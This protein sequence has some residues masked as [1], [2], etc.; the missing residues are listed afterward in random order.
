MKK[1]KYNIFSAFSGIAIKLEYSS[2]PNFFKF[3]SVSIIVLLSNRR[4]NRETSRLCSVK[5]LFGEVNIAKNYLLLE[6]G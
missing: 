4:G 2:L 5:Y 6:Y 1:M 3:Q